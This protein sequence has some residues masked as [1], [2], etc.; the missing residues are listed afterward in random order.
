[1]TDRSI[2][3]Y[4]SKC[5]TYMYSYWDS[6]KNPETLCKKCRPKKKKVLKQLTV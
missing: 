4:C 2:D 3:V 6:D 1:M 5:K